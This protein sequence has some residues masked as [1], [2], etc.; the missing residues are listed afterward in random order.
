M[1]R[2]VKL[3]END[4]ELIIG[5]VLVEQANIS[6]TSGLSMRDKEN[7]NPKNLKLGDGGNRDPKKIKDVK[8]LQK[9]LMDLGFLKT[10]SMIPTG[11]FG[12]YT[13]AA[14]D[15]YES[16]GNVR[17]GEQPPKQSQQKQLPP[18]QSQQKQLPPK[19]SQQ[20]NTPHQYYER[21][22]KELEFIKQRGL[23]DIPFFVYDP[24]K[25]LIYLFDKGAKLVNYTSVVDGADKQG[26]KE[27]KEVFTQTDW[28]KISGLSSRDG[29]YCVD[30]TITT[31]QKCDELQK[32]G[33]K[34]A[35]WYENRQACQRF[36][37]YG[38]LLKLKDR[39]LPK[40]IY[41]VKYLARNDGY[42]GAGKN[43]FMMSDS[44]GNLMTAAIHG[45]PNE[46]GRLTASA[47][48]QKKLQTD[49]STGKVPQEYLSAIKQIS[50]ANL[51]F[52]CVGV[53]AKF[54]EDPKVQSLAKGARVFVIGETEKG[55]L[56]QNSSQFFEKLGGD[57]EN[58]VNPMSLLNK[59]SNM[60]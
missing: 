11:Y 7:L 27:D 22:D 28:C 21:M 41:N 34:G 40:G 12:P 58:C 49:L 33:V 30:D 38:Q 39:F 4:L 48:L 3:T 51:S 45:I 44:E 10:K 19:Q 56:V 53:P 60:V 35:K 54:I 23:T 13:K 36:P 5:K 6:A 59:M 29:L 8:K 2:I 46:S 25:N 16:S 37:S 55:Y 9:R 52:G 57:G 1:K 32:A 31:K 15:Y 24:L 50:N 17:K 47:D 43:T 20:K 18:K 14:L 42:T 26:S